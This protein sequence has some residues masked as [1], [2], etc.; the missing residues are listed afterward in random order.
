MGRDDFTKIPNGIPSLEDRVNLYY[1]HGVKGGRIDLH[2][3]VA[4]ASTQ[5]GKDLWT[6]PAQRNDSAW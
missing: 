3:F 4:T 2:Q 5:Y 1:T 6:F